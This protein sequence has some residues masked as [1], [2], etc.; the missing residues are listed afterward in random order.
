MIPLTFYTASL[1]GP[2]LSTHSPRPPSQGCAYQPRPR[3]SAERRRLIDQIPSSVFFLRCQCF[4]SFRFS[5]FTFFWS[6]HSVSVSPSRLV[7]FRYPVTPDVFLLDSIPACQHISHHHVVGVSPVYFTSS[8]L[9]IIFPFEP[10]FLLI[11]ISPFSLCFA[12]KKR[13][14]RSYVL[15]VFL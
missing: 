1:H 5:I 8:V 4:V 11:L 2:V 12:M 13:S 6:F 9:F 15:F 7:S 14:I 10:L 3:E